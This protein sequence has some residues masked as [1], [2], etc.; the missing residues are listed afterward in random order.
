[1]DELYEKFFT[2]CRL[3]QRSRFHHR[4]GAFRQ[5]DPSR[6][7][8]RVLAALRMKEEISSREL[9]YL[10]GIRQ[11]SLNEML[12]KLEAAG[13]VERVPSQEDRRVILV[14]LTEK[15]REAPLDGGQTGAEA[16]D[17]LN[18]TEREA[19]SRYLDR[20]IANL[21]VQLETEDG[22]ELRGRRH[23]RHGG[24]G[25]GDFFTGMFQ[26]EDGTWRDEPED[27]SPD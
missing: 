12:V 11:Q 14:R 16:F 4:G 10:L 3:M 19:L 23:G 17:C 15:G 9:C 22:G 7:Q 8:G 24:F 20:M 13:L 21:T 18:P 2:L 6:G 27:G 26:N 25:R 1:M 5:I